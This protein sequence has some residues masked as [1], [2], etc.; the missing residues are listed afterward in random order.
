MTTAKTSGP[1][2]KKL[3]IWLALLVFGYGLLGA[4]LLPWWLERE[5]PKRMQA[6]MGWSATVDDIRVNPFAFSVEA[7]GFAA[8]D[9]A[10]E[11]VL[12]FDSLSANLSLWQLINGVIAFE[13]ITLDQ[14]F[15]R[16][17]LLQDYGVNFSRDWQT[18]NPADADDAN[19][20]DSGGGAPALYF[21]RI[22]LNNGDI[23]LRDFSQGRDAE[24]RIQP[25]T[26]ELT[27]LATYAR[28]GSSDY[29]LN[30]AIGE[31]TIT[32]EGDLSF[33]PLTSSG[34]IAVNNLEYPTLW[35]FARDAVPY[36]LRSG[37]V[38][39]TTDYQLSWVDELAL[40]TRDGVVNVRGLSVATA[41]N[42]DPAALENAD[43]DVDGFE[44]DLLG[45]ELAIDK[46]ALRNAAMTVQRNAQGILNLLAPLNSEE[47][48]SADAVDAPQAPPS[49][50]FRWSVKAI[51]VA[52][53]RLHW[54]DEQPVV[55]AD[56]SLDA[57]NLSL[58]E[59]SDELEQP[60]DYALAFNVADGGDVS[61]QGQATLQPFTLE[62]SLSAQ[63]LALAAFEPY[64]RESAAL[65]IRDG[66]LSFDGSID[67]DGQT[68][69]LT[70]TFSGRGRVENLDALLP[71]SDTPLIAWSSLVLEPIEYNLAPARLEIGKITLSE[72][73]VSVAR[74]ESGNHNVQRIMTASE[75][76]PKPSAE[77]PASAE[78]AAATGTTPAVI[79]RVREFVLDKG[80]VDYSDRSVQPVFTTQLSDLDGTVTGLSNIPPQQAKVAING[81]VGDVGAIQVD[82][83][84]GT[85]GADSSSDLKLTLSQLSLPQ[86][87]PYLGR[88][89]GYS[90]DSG[91]LALNLDY[92]I[93]G[94]LLNGK[95][96]VTLDR[97]ELGGPINSDLAVNAPVKLGLALLR[98][99]N[100]VIDINL[101][102][103]GNL[104]DPDFR[105][106]QVMMSTFVN[107]VVKAATSPFSV[108]GSVV[109][110]A[111]LSGAE[112]GTIAFNPGE[113]ELAPKEQEKVAA[114][115]KVL[116][117]RSELLLNI[118]GAVAPELDRP[119]L[120]RQQVFERLGLGQGTPLSSRIERLEQAYEQ[121]SGAEALAALKQQ[122][123]NTGQNASGA[124]WEAAL[125]AALGQNI[126][127]SSEALQSLAAVRGT[128]IQ[129][130]LLDSYDTPQEQ[131]YL[132]DP[133][134]DAPVN[135]GQQQVTVQFQLDVR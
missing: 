85:L 3:V 29:R 129:R 92:R 94:T 110:L 132:L 63:G 121:S 75:G 108:L 88:Y 82:G 93:D 99:G 65:K 106:G 8:T 14:P 101:P 89:L 2:Y 66:R 39:V 45:R 41:E 83:S 115:A 90:I 80:Q 12:N 40:V 49:Q 25:L 91:K 57:I 9:S 71:D 103:E 130:R 105:L 11:P 6:H 70:G 125:V 111:G 73:R 61:F 69:P 118:R 120:K 67:L 122:A 54:L 10:N 123:R 77:P 87:S 15:I 32:W 18:H 119:G 135:N 1:W 38:S 116:S 62:A 27:D 134:L 60:V 124:A 42:D 51:E 26:I 127:I 97:M 16:I 74:L 50:P 35:H 20:E 102:I 22:S 113:S 107:L 43:I 86:L 109:D 79:F 114:L 81:R 100:G 128:N 21:G 56:V 30:A 23:N 112:L 19:A 96:Q 33:A 28:E 68:E 104:S 98:D 17:D 55:A 58:T 4:G 64:I 53:G 5:L 7:T 133:L 95:N 59:L 52:D 31:Q 117:E 72:P 78:S 24:F 84:I 36:S 126:S 48:G 47:A 34:R 46:I 44:F 131:L 37:T 76:S 13:H